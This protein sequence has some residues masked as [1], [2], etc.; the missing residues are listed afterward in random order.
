MRVVLI[1]AAVL[2]MGACAN[3]YHIRADALPVYAALETAP[4]ASSEDAADDPAIWIH[5]EDP[6]KSLILGTNKQLGLGVYDL[7]GNEVQFIERGRLNNVDLRQGVRIGNDIVT[8]AAATNRTE[9]TLDIFIIEDSGRLDHIM[10]IPLSMVDPYG[11]CMGL[12]D[13][14]GAHVFANSREF[15]YEHWHLNPGF[16]LA[17]KLV[18]S[19][20][21]NSGP[22]G[23]SVHDET[24]ILYLGEEEFGVWMMPADGNRA[25][26]MTLLEANSEGHL[27]ADVEGMDVYQGTSGELY[28][29][30]SSQGDNSFAVYDLNDSNRYRG[31][32]RIADA[33]DGSLDGVQETDGLAVTSVTLSADFPMG[34]LVV[35]DGYNDLPTEHQNFKLVS[36]QAIAEVLDL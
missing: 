36:W 5:P 23:C 27:T 22:E 33:E 18:A 30:V 25:N 20:H 31:S 9:I 34:M 21:M 6:S 26:E 2:L 32:F 29:I 19:W 15:E 35:Q 17:P 28:L 8:L 4:V 10:A 11:L 1:L 3:P 12:D 7:E 24:Q 14:G 13:E 16:T